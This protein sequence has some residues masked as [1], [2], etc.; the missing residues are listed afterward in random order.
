MARSTFNLSLT[1]YIAVNKKNIPPIT[2]TKHV[3]N[4]AYCSD[5]NFTNEVGSVSTGDKDFFKLSDI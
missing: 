3:T 2:S 5:L 1:M 4:K